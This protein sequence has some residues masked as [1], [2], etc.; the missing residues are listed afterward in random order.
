MVQKRFD[1]KILK[2]GKDMA[3]LAVV[4][5]LLNMPG[6]NKEGKSGPNDEPDEG[7]D[8]AFDSAINQWYS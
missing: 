2:K 8:S 5:K 1:D 6:M 3:S 4:S 7:Q